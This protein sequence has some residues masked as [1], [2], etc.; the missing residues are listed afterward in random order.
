MDSPK[1][2]P[3]INLPATPPV[4]PSPAPTKTHNR[5]RVA[6]WT[7][8]S[9]ASRLALTDYDS[10]PL[11]TEETKPVESFFSQSCNPEDELIRLSLYLGPGL[12]GNP[13]D[14]VAGATLNSATRAKVATKLWVYLDNL[15][16]SER[17][18]MVR[19]RVL[20]L[21]GGEG[22]QH[23][24]V[25]GNE[26][27]LSGESGTWDLLDC[28]QVLAEPTTAIYSFYSKPREDKG[29]AVL[30]SFFRKSPASA[31][32]DKQFTFDDDPLSVLEALVGF[33]DVN[34]SNTQTW[35]QL[36]AGTA[37]Y[38]GG[39]L[40]EFLTNPKLCLELWR[41][42]AKIDSLLAKSND[43][44][45]PSYAP[46]SESDTNGIPA[47]DSNKP[48]A[49]KS[50]P[51]VA[52]SHDDIAPA[53]AEL[54]AQVAHLSLENET[55]SRE[56]LDLTS[57]LFAREQQISEQSSELTEFRSQL[58]A[59]NSR[60]KDLESSLQAQISIAA[61]LSA[62]ILLKD[63]E[64]ASKASKLYSNENLLGVQSSTLKAQT[65]RVQQL[66]G[67]L[68]G[69]DEKI[70]ILEK[71]LEGN[72]AEVIRLNGRVVELEGLA[73]Q[74]EQEPVE[75][76]RQRLETSETARNQA[77]AQARELSDRLRQLETQIKNLTLDLESKDL[78]VAQKQ[79]IID[80]LQARAAAE[81]NDLLAR[82]RM[83]MVSDAFGRLRADR[84]SA[85]A[86]LQ[87]RL[88]GLAAEFL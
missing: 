64:I 48:F 80:N 20:G 88:E 76:L 66:E 85:T 25:K 4:S 65:D 87:A 71:N 17:P 38:L 75:D 28:S 84:R 61:N 74:R 49:V 78:L 82:E 34:R 77:L 40:T 32:V 30:E 69:R 16:G 46:G 52:G 12:A 9:P 56:I 21:K 37:R 47:T 5:S 68:K 45:P 33:L 58:H 54:R 23:L 73:Q 29:H 35:N 39:K 13:R 57:R 15:H 62:T 27:K 14:T 50:E 18:F 31:K 79:K 6:R 67:D 72:K 11:P 60:I 42:R 26:I 86:S 22:E 24:D 1:K 51:N 44:A 43:G 70:E 19:E 36:H 53:E 81:N 10:Q 3:I 7:Q 8:L 55:K 59:Q 41:A 83:D 2:P 63:S